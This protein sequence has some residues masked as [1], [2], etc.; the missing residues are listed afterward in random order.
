MF[1]FTHYVRTHTYTIYVHCVYPAMSKSTKQ[2]SKFKRAEK[3]IVRSYRCHL[4]RSCFTV[5]LFV[6]FHSTSIGA[7]EIQRFSSE[8]KTGDLNPA[9]GEL[10]SIQH[11]VIKFVSSWGQDGGFLWILRFSPLIILTTTILLKYCWKWR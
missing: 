7:G 9:H 4:S 10:S 1:I 3:S 5:T 8:I 11:Y 6:I 2:L